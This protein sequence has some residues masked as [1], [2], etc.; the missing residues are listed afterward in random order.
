MKF[1]LKVTLNSRTLKKHPI[2]NSNDFNSYSKYMYIEL[3]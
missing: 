3:Q 1:D 2:D